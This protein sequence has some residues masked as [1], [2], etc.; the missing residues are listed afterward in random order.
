M[1]TVKELIG[2]LQ[3]H[4]G[5]TPIFVPS[6]IGYDPATKADIQSVCY[7]GS[8]QEPGEWELESHADEK[9]INRGQLMVVVI[10]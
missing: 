10:E 3:K 2:Q 4:D 8:Y 1:L 5:N 7:R 6:V 9:A